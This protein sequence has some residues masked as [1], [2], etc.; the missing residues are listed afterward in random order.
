MNLP[1]K[2]RLIVIGGL[3]LVSFAGAFVV[4]LTTGGPEP[5]EVRLGPNGEKP[6]EILAATGISQLE[7]LSPKEHQ[8]DRLIKEMRQE[9]KSYE[10]RK[11]ELVLLEKRTQL[12]EENLRRQAQ[13]LENLRV[14]I[15]SALAPLKEERAKL[16]RERVRISREERQ[17]LQRV[18]SVYSKMSSDAAA[19]T[20]TQMMSDGQEKDA[21]RI[22]HFMDE[23]S[24]GKILAEFED[25][26]TAAKISE[27]MKRIREE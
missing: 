3:A 22:L 21:V 27:M 26:T 11:R 13:E 17:N 16:V 2:L 20:L 5:E 14:E 25:K 8:L 12:A 4:A 24:A 6:G 15:A 19:A 1:P 23:R 7:R 10:T 18:A 9:I